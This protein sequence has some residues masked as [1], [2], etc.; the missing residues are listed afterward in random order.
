MI[1]FSEDLYFIS[2]ENS[3]GSWIKARLK[4]IVSSGTVVN[5]APITTP[6]Y[7]MLELK[8][9]KERIV[10]GKTVASMKSSKI[11][12]ETGTRVIAAFKEVGTT[13]EIKKPRHD[14]FYPGIVAEPPVAQNKYR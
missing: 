7:K 6:H 2:R 10:N 1:N 11:R 3:S 14:P 13:G 5:G 4:S 9:H 12:L 8:Q